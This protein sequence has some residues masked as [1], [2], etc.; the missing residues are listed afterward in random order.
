MRSRMDLSNSQ[1]N[2]RLLQT[3]KH[4]CF[5]KKAISKLGL[6][7]LLSL[8]C[9]GVVQAKVIYTEDFET[10][11]GAITKSHPSLHLS[12]N[13]PVVVKAEKG[14]TP[15]GGSHMMKSYLHRYNSNT[16]YRTEATI[17]RYQN[18][19]GLFEK[20]KDYWLGVSIFIPADWSMDYRGTKNGKPVEDRLGG[21]IVLQ[22]HDRSYKSSTYRSGL[23]FVVSH[24][25]DGFRIWNR[26]D[27]CRKRPECLANTNIKNTIKRFSEVAPMKR[28]QWNDFV[29][30]VKWSPNADGL[31]K[32]WVNGKLELDSKGPNY[33]N[34]HPASVY[35]YFKMGLYQSSFGKSAWSKDI[36]WNTLERTLY[37]DE[38]R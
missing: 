38:L 34:E 28:G 29:M 14:I 8:S 32:L 18:F 33:H 13:A 2:L 20:D 16:T 24:S 23:P 6:M 1:L 3:L 7:G 36:K 25:K 11:T 27:G 21:G 10:N 5:N 17:H 12:G 35:P 26:T 22:F 4:H 9:L 37:H 15:R 31:L 19:S 30:Q